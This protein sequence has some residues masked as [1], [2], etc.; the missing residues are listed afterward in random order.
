MTPEHYELSMWLQCDHDEFVKKKT[1]VEK[2][3]LIFCLQM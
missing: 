2:D 3:K 1:D